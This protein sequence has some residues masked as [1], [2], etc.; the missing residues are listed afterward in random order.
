MQKIQVEEVMEALSTRG[1]YTVE[2]E[3]SKAINTIVVVLQQTHHTVEHARRRVI[4]S[5]PNG[6]EIDDAALGRAIRL[7]IDDQFGTDAGHGEPF[8]RE[9]AKTLALMIRSGKGIF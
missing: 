5:Y 6:Y 8:E 4:A 2:Q 7:A 9:F 3:I 1:P